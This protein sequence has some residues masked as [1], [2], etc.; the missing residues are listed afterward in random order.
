MYVNI[1]DMVRYLS[2]K[3]ADVNIKD[4]NGVGK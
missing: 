2:D 3:G 1:V 4:G